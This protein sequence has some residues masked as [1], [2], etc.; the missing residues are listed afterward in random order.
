MNR[1]SKWPEGIRYLFVGGVTTVI[2]IVIYKALLILGG[3]YGMATTVAFLLSVSSAYVM[4]S[5]YV[6]Y[7]PLS[8]R[9]LLKF[10]GA[11][12][13]TFAFETVGLV[14]L[15]ECF[16]WEPFMAKC[17][18]TIAVV[19]L[20]YILSKIWIFKGEEHDHVDESK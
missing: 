10:M 17:V 1:H 13:S 5:F 7:S 19:L 2:N 4:N 16:L 6:F 18:I 9:R 8:L 3:A 15:I 14:L 12:L 11:R 20:N